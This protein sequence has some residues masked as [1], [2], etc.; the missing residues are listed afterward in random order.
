MNPL[1]FLGGSWTA[2]MESFQ[3]FHA[4]AVSNL[5]YLLTT[6]AWFLLILAGLAGTVIMNIMAEVDA[7]YD[8]S[9]AI[10]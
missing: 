2:M 7:S 3:A 9:Q 4:N 6:N 10:I 5:V 1:S 8:T